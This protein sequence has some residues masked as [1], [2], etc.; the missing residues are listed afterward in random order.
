MVMRTIFLRAVRRFQIVLAGCEARQCLQSRKLRR[1]GESRNLGSLMFNSP[2][3]NRA[4]DGLEVTDGKQLTRKR[5]VL[6]SS[7]TQSAPL[8]YFPRVAP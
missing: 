7:D 4:A 5:N 8:S 1:L 2:R 6:S 3:V